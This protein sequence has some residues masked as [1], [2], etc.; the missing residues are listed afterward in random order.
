MSQCDSSTTFGSIF[1]KVTQD[2]LLQDSFVYAAPE[3]AGE[4][5]LVVVECDDDD[6]TC[7]A[8]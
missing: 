6:E 8:G 3:K 2:Y 7:G 1:G 5:T 4:Y